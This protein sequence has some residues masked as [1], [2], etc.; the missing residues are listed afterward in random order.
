MKI[1]LG[2]MPEVWADTLEKV[3]EPFGTEVHRFSQ[4]SEIPQN[5]E[6]LLVYSRPEYAIE[7]AIVERNDIHEALEDWKQEAEALLQF[8]RRNR[9]QADMVHGPCVFDLSQ[10]FC[11]FLDRRFHISIS[12]A[13]IAAVKRPEV[14]K[15]VFQVIAAQAVVASTELTDFVGELEASSQPIGSGPPLYLPQWTEAYLELH[16]LEKDKKQMLIQLHQVQEE[17]ERHYLEAK[18]LRGQ[19]DEQKNDL[20]KMTTERDQNAQKVKVLET[21][22]EKKSV[23]IGKLSKELDKLKQENIQPNKELEEE[24]ELLLFQLHQV[25]EKLEIYYLE[26]KELQGCAS[27]MDMD[28]LLSYAVMLEHQYTK[29]LKSRSWK[30]M[31][32]IREAGRLLKSLLRRKRVPRNRLPKRPK[33]L[34][35]EP[36]GGRYGKRTRV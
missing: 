34:D 7:A 27:S 4:G 10:E 8:F 19:R 13:D 29:L 22:L 3:L 17:L 24:N 31:A 21:E 25:Q 20:E 30:L 15:T 16:E 11:E 6:V 12:P 14:D 35:S 23:E 33:V 28:E 2:A 18:E 32:P 26:V 1:V 9:R 5:E 36:V